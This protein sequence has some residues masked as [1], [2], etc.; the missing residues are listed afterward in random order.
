MAAKM[1]QIGPKLL[2]I[3][4]NKDQL[5]LTH[6]VAQQ[7]ISNIN[8]INIRKNTDQHKISKLDFLLGTKYLKFTPLQQQHQQQQQ[9][10]CEYISTLH[11]AAAC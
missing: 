9:C 1:L 2:N 4:T 8:D 5:I 10:V 7:I 6:H 11:P 3:Y